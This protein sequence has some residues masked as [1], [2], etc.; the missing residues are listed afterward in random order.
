IREMGNS[1]GFDLYIQNTGGLT[2]AEFVDAR[3]QLLGMASQDPRLMGVRPNGS[4]D[5]PQ[6]KMNLDYQKAQALGVSVADAT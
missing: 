6:F 2:H 5:G 4:E 1:N 3:N